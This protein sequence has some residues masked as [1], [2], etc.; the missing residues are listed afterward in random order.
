M[1]EHHQH[2]IVFS[3][4]DYLQVNINEGTNVLFLKRLNNGG[5]TLIHRYQVRAL[6]G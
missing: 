6:S 1:C 4:L 5:F 2:M 3:T